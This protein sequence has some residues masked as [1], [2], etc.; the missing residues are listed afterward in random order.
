MTLD[1][2]WRKVAVQVNFRCLAQNVTIKKRVAKRFTALTR[3]RSCIPR[4][5]SQSR[6]SWNIYLR[7]HAAART[8][9]AICFRCVA[10]YC[11]SC[12]HSRD[13]ET[14]DTIELAGTT[15]RQI[16]VGCRKFSNSRQEPYTKCKNFLLSA[17]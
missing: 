17:K 6:R 8:N 7:V 15:G 3:G 11:G 9:P 1:A 14:T 12:A 4:R 2:I 16:N 5:V 10:S 13:R